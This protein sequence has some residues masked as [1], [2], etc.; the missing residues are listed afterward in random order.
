MIKSNLF[1]AAFERGFGSHATSPAIVRR[2]GKIPKYQARIDSDEVHFWFKVN[3]KASAIPNQP[4]H[5][6]PVIESKT[7]RYNNRDDGLL[8]WYQYTDAE[9]I[10]QMTQLQW[11]V[12]AKAGDQQ[13]FELDIW[14]DLLMGSC[15]PLMKTSIEMGFQPG[16]P[17]TGLYYLDEADAAAWGALFSAQLVQWLERYRLAPE[18]LEAYMWRVHWN[19]L[20]EQASAKPG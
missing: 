12:F 18:T 1:Y 9:M 11:G 13:T 5:F 3:P 17:H 8:S 16:S 2:R 6:W 10:Q 4:G 15:L 20:N 14:R 19:K 7:L